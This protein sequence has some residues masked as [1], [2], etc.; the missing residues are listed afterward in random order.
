MIKTTIIKNKSIENEDIP[1]A[2]RIT[3]LIATTVIVTII[4]IMII[5]ICNQIKI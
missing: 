5:K 3:Q 2:I 4:M 1:M